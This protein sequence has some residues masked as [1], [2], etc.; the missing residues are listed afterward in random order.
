MKCIVCS[1]YLPHN[2]PIENIGGA[3]YCGDCA[4]K[5]GLITS[6]RY[7]KAHLY[8]ICLDGIKATVHNGIIYIGM[9]EKPFDFEKTAK[10]YRKTKE[11]I[12]WRAQVFERDNFQCQICGQIGGTLNA[13]HIKEF[14][15]YEGLRYEVGNGVTLCEA[16]HRELHKKKRRRKDGWQT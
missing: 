5:Q 10:D 6:E 3:V 16:C 1:E 2:A 14:S 9:Q 4:F 11:Y 15:K 7:I 8:W 12:E 13:H